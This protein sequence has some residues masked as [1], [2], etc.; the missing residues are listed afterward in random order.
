MGGRDGK[1]WRPFVSTAELDQLDKNPTRESRESRLP[2]WCAAHGAEITQ[3]GA[4]DRNDSGGQGGGR[5]EGETAG[6]VR[7]SDVLWGWGA[8]S[9]WAF[10]RDSARTMALSGSGKVVT[11]SAMLSTRPGAHKGNI[12]YV[13][14]LTRRRVEMSSTVLDCRSGSCD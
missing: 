6:A 10:P 14:I 1:V 7:P 4:R 8:E 3:A 2:P 5:S 11:A 13:A 12:Q 9:A